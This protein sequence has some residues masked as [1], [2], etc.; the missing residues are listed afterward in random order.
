MSEGSTAAAPTTV[1]EVSEDSTDATNVALCA[2]H[3]V[4]AILSFDADF[5]GV[6]SGID[7]T[8]L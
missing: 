5:D 6:V 3:D 2:R 1:K 7:P 8:D 4:D